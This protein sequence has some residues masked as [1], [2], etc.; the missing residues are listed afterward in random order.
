VLV[1]H[2]HKGMLP[3]EQSF[4]KVDEENVMVTVLKKAEDTDNAVLRLYE[5]RGESSETNI[6]LFERS[7]QVQ[8]NPCE[9]KTFLIPR[10]KKVSIR[11]VNLLEL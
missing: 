10:D 8:L 3:K 11:E 2:C 6:T 7:W 1:E 5:T 4:I 9:I